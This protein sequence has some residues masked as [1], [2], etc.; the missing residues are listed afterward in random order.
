MLVWSR[1]C[2]FSI[3]ETEITGSGLVHFRQLTCS[4]RDPH[5]SRSSNVKIARR[6]V[7]GV[8]KFLLIDCIG[9]IKSEKH[10]VLG[11]LREFASLE[12]EI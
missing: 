11:M 10:D 2:T 8:G 12:S 1:L 9:I 6:R 5:E 4:T 7:E 3:N